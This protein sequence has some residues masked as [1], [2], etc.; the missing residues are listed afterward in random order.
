MSTNTPTK[1][2]KD[3]ERSKGL[4]IPGWILLFILFV[5]QIGLFIAFFVV[6]LKSYY[7]L[8][9]IVYVFP[10]VSFGCFCYFNEKFYVDRNKSIR[11]VWIIWGTYI[12]AYVITVAV[13]FASFAGN[14][15]KE[16]QLGINALMGTLCITPGLLILL[17]QLTI[18]PSYRNTILPSAFF[19]AL[20]IFDGI[21]MLEVYLM[22]KE[23]NFELDESIEIIIIIFACLCFFISPFGLCENKFKPDGK[24]EQRNNS[25]WFWLL[26]LLYVLINNLPFL[27][28]R[29]IIWEK[30]ESAIFLGKNAIALLM[31]FVQFLISKRWCKCEVKPKTSNT[32][33]SKEVESSL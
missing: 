19:C 22:Q 8:I 1:P 28:I 30:Y 24:V 13:F 9:L 7:P 4:V 21:E 20:N 12:L 33:H 26:R 27:I 16:D 25:W 17:V 6:H 18:C 2:K 23:A 11:G 31:E 15:T 29:A 5:S 32:D 3:I 10:L 14:L